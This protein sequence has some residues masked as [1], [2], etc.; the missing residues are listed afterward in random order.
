MNSFP[1]ARVKRTGVCILL[2]CVSVGISLLAERSDWLTQAENTYYDAWHQLA[3]RRFLPSHALIVAV[4]N[5][6][7]LAH[8]DE[9]LA[10][11][12]PHFAKVIQRLREAGVRCI[13]IDFL[14]SVSAESWLKRIQTDNTTISRT[15]D[16]PFREE[17]NKGGVIL[18]GTAVRNAEGQTRLLLPKIEFLF[19]LPNNYQDIGLSN[20]YTDDDEVIR[21]FIPK[22]I[23]GSESPTLIFA[24]LMAK[25]V[26]E[27]AKSRQ[28]ET[29]SYRRIGYAGPPGTYPRISFEQL[30]SSTAGEAD[31][32]RRLKDKLVIIAVENVGTHDV[33]LT[34][35]MTRIIGKQTGAMTG[36]EIHAN[37]I[38]TLLEDRFPREQAGSIRFVWLLLLTVIGTG[39]FFLKPPLLGLC[40]WGLLNLSAAVAAY[41]LFRYNQVFPVAI[42]NLSSSF[43][44]IGA[45][46]LRLTREERTRRLMRQAIGP[47]VSQTVVDQVIDSEHLP[48]LGGETFKVAVLF[49]D[50]RDFTTISE[51]LSAA[52]V[53]EMLNTYFSR[54]CEPIL[55][56]GG[57]I[58]KFI[59]DAVMA[60][61]GAPAPHPDFA[62][63]AIKAALEMKKIALDFQSWMAQR[64]YDKELPSFR[65]GIGLHTG[66]AVI[67]NIGSPRR[68]GYTAIG[69][70][71][72]I[73]SRLEGMSKTLGWTIVASR[74]III[75]AGTGVVTGGKDTISVK[76]RCGQIEVAE[77]TDMNENHDHDNR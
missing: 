21:S 66:L 50:I 67:G 25:R 8:E 4:D 47:Y 35:Y 20:L 36:A 9:P 52:E 77:V 10:F 22:I 55:A 19:S 27:E 45:L 6:T 54:I 26:V 37:I 2:I 29:M 13:G 64:F 68:M 63:R 17:L 76:G 57:M 40:A 42:I 38:D 59:G 3:G 74:D 23:E 69:D 62:L 46:G 15:Y 49:S 39:F 44:Y 75:E 1:K 5:A 48:N 72:N 51:A 28:L 11:W 12:G 71:V 14:F 58:D 73:A 32:N 53:V 34:P 33:H 70:T 43:A 65:V 16:I 56:Q 7:L 24:S 61:F 60:V 18:I 31:L 30:L 41:V